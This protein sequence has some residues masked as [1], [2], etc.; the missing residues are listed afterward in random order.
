MRQFTYDS[1]S[2]LRTAKNPEQVNA[3][4]QMV[5]TVY[6]YD[7]SSNLITRTNPNGTTVGFTYDGLNR[8]MTK[9]L[10]VG[11]AFTY[12]YD[13]AT[14]GK[15]RLTSVTSA[16]GSGYYYDSYDKAGKVT[17]SH[18]VTTG[19]SSQ[20]SYTMSY[21]Y[22]LAGAKTT[23]KYPSG[24]E[25]RTSYDNAGRV[26][27]VSRY[28]SS[29]LDKTYASGF[30][31]SSHGA[32]SAMSLSYIS[33]SPKM[34]E[35]TSYNSRL[36][37]T[38]MEMRK[39]GTNE[40]LLGLDY[41]YGT[42]ANNGNMQTQGIRIGGTVTATWTMNQTFTY[43][44]LNRLDLATETGGWS[45]DLEY[46]RYGNRW[47]SGGIIV[48]GNEALTPQSPQAFIAATNR[49]STSVYDTSGN[50]TQDGAGRSFTYDAENRMLTFNGTAAAYAYDGDGRRVK[51]TDGTGTTVFVYNAGGQLV[52]E[53]SS[54]G[55][56]P[57]G[58][59]Y[60][61]TD[62]L[63]STRLVTDASGTVKARHD[64]L[65]FGEEVPSSQGIRGS[66]SGYAASD[67]TRQRF[68]Q[69]E[70]DSESGLD[71][72]LARY[73]SSAQGRFT[74]VDTG[75]FELINP[76]TWNRY[77]YGLNN[78]LRYIDPDG[79]Q[80]KESWYKPILD[81]LRTVLG[82]KASFNDHES[83]REAPRQPN[84]LGLSREQMV[85]EHF[86]AIVTAS[87]INSEIITTLDPTGGSSVVKS[88]M[89]RN[90]S[91][92]ALSAA[93]ILPNIF[94]VGKA[95]TTGELLMGRLGGAHVAAQFSKK[96]STLIA[97]VVG[98][99]GE[100]GGGSLASTT[101]SLFN[102]I[103]GY[104]KEEG[105]S[106]VKLQAVAV[107]NKDLE[108]KLVKQGWEVTTVVVDGETVTAYTKTFQVR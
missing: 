59:S 79:R 108:Q 30:S 23:E 83:R 17:A 14:N 75:K 89:E 18:Q 26:S 104:A 35:Q 57:N 43:D 36:Q 4:S 58:T 81:Y 99:F 50:Q 37:S 90:K 77:R 48:P 86:R 87:R 29:A 106:K 21:G 74:G 98:V 56:Q 31:Y 92:T 6:T 84:Q 7:D 25:Y 65:P 33:G 101:K 97:D 9:T 42:T 16:G 93:M 88:F 39:G 76:Q 19:P 3:A 103:M 2:R 67:G 68:T 34:T 52:A 8:V 80:E 85:Q 78:P 54:G 47:V 96:G 20:Q 28:I 12:T 38:K 13:T 41:G 15:G 11:G 64:Y 82:D 53:Y 70:R 27:Q 45:Q 102:A 100:K 107:V 105:L 22:N 61:T 49:L 51:K 10:S 94:G 5:A 63:G 62:H 60:L 91:G 72:F 73:Y 71:Y 69:K 1:L 24:K 40:L 46:D 66:V 32:V 95:L 55:A 44:A